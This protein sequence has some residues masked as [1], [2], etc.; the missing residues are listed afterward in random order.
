MTAAVLAE[1]VA[2]AQQPL[3]IAGAGTKS[4]Y[5]EALGANRLEVASLCGI[6]AYE[7]AELYVTVGAG[8]SLKQLYA[9]LAEQGQQPAA[10]LGGPP[11]ATVGGTVACALTGPERPL[12]GLV[13]DHVLGCQII[14]G[15]G[16]LQ[17][18]G[19]TLIKNVAGYDVTR[20]M[21]GAQ[22]TLGVITEVVL[23]TRGLAETCATVALECAASEALATCSRL[24]NAGVPLAASAWSVNVLR[25]RFA[26]SAA[27]VKR[28]CSTAGGDL[29][30]DT[31]YWQKL[32]EGRDARFA[33]TG[34]IWLCHLPVAAQLAYDA[35]ALIEWHGARRW[36]FDDAPPEL[37][38]QVATAGGSSAL[39]RRGATPPDVPAFE[40]PPPALRSLHERLK[41]VFDP[42]G[43]LNPGRLSFI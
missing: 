19:G 41:Q 13:Q 14:T 26:G 32:R 24:A 37:R 1:Q 21:V 43:I 17:R 12:R 15:T 28:A 42:R 2:A 30:A 6:R 40:T 29:L 22:G 34:T 10:D 9:T 38:T 16:S 20:L 25:L 5:G 27:A 33:G 35:N 18:Y 7:P 31:D 23:R 39:Y 36:F 3:Y 4:G 8:T 11:E